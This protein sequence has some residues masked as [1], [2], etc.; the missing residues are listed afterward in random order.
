MQRRPLPPPKASNKQ[1]QEYTAAVLRGQK[2]QHVI[3]NPDG[4][5]TVKRLGVPKSSRAFAT[6]LEAIRYGKAIAQHDKTE[7]FIHG[8]D[9]HIRARNSYAQ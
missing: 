2:S 9:G 7:L 3:P 5:W 4:G 6:Q 1:I 8:K